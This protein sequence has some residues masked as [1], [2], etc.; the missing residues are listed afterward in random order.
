MSCEKELTIVIPCLNEERTIAFCIDKALSAFRE[1]DINGEVLVVDNGSIDNSVEVACRA[2]ARVVRQE[3]K[4]YGSALLKGFQEAGGRFIVMGDADGTYDFS[5]LDGFINLLRQG[6]DFVMGS[7]FRGTIVPGAMPLHHRYLGTPVLTMVVNFFFGAHISDVNC[8]MRGFT[9]EAILKLDLKSPGMEFASEMI[10]KA[11]AEGLTIKE[12]PVNLYLPPVE[13][14]PHLNSFRDGWRHLRFMLIFCPKY[15]FLYPGLLLFL[16]GT[17]V[18]ILLF[19]RSTFFDIQ[20]GLSTAVLADSLLLIGAQVSLFGVYSII[21]QTS[22]RMVKEDRISAF[23]Q[24]NFTLERGLC[25]GGALFLT[26]GLICAGVFS[27]FLTSAYNLDHV[28]I[29]LTRG[30]IGSIFL[31]LVGLQ[32]IFSSFYISIFNLSKTL[33]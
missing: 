18:T 28:N 11:V 9:K 13:R 23:L 12:I 27:A 5:A 33:R 15:L 31:A 21:I 25:I 24:R 26:G 2:G 7:R 4:G 17:L 20:F 6:V 16:L 14:T 1:L 10:I 19:F 29:P 22:Q 32:I 8:G 30:A 3:I